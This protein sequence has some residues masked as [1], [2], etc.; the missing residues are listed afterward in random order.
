[1]YRR[2]EKIIKIGNVSGCACVTVE[3]ATVIFSDNLTYSS[4]HRLGKLPQEITSK[5]ISN[6]NNN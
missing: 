1:M 5:P 6:S 3:M 2:Y 4:T